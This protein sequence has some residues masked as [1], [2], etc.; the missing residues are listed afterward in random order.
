V[1]EIECQ[2]PVYCGREIGM[3]DLQC[4]AVVEWN[5]EGIGMNGDSLGSRTGL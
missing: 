1:W 5:F 4:A 2:F 3:N